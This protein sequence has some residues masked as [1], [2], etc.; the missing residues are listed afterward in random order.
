MKSAR[1]RHRLELAV[2]AAILV[3][4]AVLRTIQYAAQGSMWLDELAV[5]INVTSRSFGQLVLQPLDLNQVAPPGF[6]A[7]EKLGA[8][9][10]GHDGAGLRL[11]PWIASLASLFLFWRV[12]MRFTSGDALAAG[13]LAFAASP[14]LVW[15]AGNAKQ[16]SGDVAVTL[17]LLLLALQVDEEA[18]GARQGALW[19]LVGGAAILASQ[20]AVLVATGLCLVL[21]ARRLRSRRPLAPVLALGAGWAIGAAIVTAQ[22]VL[23]VSD[24]T[25]GSM[26]ASWADSFLPAPWEGP[27]QLLWLPA[28]LLLLFGHLLI[29]VVP[30]SVPEILF[31]ATFGGLALAGAR[32]LAIRRPGPA[33]LLAVPL[34]VGVLAAAIHLLPLFDRV[35]LYLSPALLI[36]A[37][38]GADDVSAHFS[39]RAW[40]AASALA[41]L[42]FALPAAAVVALAP[43]P[44]RAEETRPVLEELGSR[45]R[46]GDAIYVYYAAELAMRFY[47]PDVE[48]TRGTMHQRD[49]R[50]YFRELDALRG[51]Q[52][53]WFFHTHGFPC[54]PEA[55]RSYLEAIGTELAKIEDPFGLRGQREAAAY[56]YDLSDPGRLTQADA[57][58][59][60]FPAATGLDWQTEGCGY[61][62]RPGEIVGS[63]RVERTRALSVRGREDLGP[64]NPVEIGKLARQVGVPLLLDSPLVG[65]P[66]PRRSLPVSSVEGVDDVH[67]LDDLPDGGE[68]HLVEPGVVA[69]ADEQLGRSGPGAGGS[70][71]NPPARVAGRHGVVGYAGCLPGAR[72][73]RVAGYPELRHEALDDPEEAHALEEAFTDEVVEAVDPDRRPVALR[74]DHEVATGGLERDAKRIRRFLVHGWTLRLKQG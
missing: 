15:Y 3:F 38:A 23:V 11:F 20:P 64:T 6:L 27:V 51:R 26:T 32:R 50:A 62:R 48:W 4:G 59:H 69:I 70:E 13:L 30:K 18:W 40:A 28:R 55:I 10:L 54:E 34:V 60:P 49:S 17:L 72:H 42:P 61:K 22:S 58:T 41:F 68:P 31:V 39:G 19:G 36:A 47:G 53:V 16:Y 25:V 21:V 8:V 43:P 9:L 12:A 1:D 37:M 56:L 65:P 67:P 5:A 74:F 57:E 44:Y 2:C 33:L 14:A 63:R 71:R 24:A 46:R 66:A 7:L 52:R 29:R 73:E 35:S 45:W